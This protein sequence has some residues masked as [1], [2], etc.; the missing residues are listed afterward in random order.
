M[1]VVGL[2]GGIGSGK[3]TVAERFAAR[4]VPVVD[5]DAIARDLMAQD[6]AALA[7]VT[8]RFGP[9]ILRA[10]G[11]LDRAALRRIVFDDPAARA[12]LEGILH[13]LI[14][15]EA[16]R[17]LQ[18][19]SASYALLAVPLLVETGVCREYV[20]RVLTIEC[21]EPVRIERVMARSG[22]TRGEVAAIVAAQASDA[23]RRAVA[24]DVLDNAGAPATL[25]AAVA[26]LHARY[27]AL[28]QAGL[29]GFST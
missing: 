29:A 19:L 16:E 26:R 25:D 5:T 24:D 8:A 1:F 28:A 20:Q 18:A 22:L 15:R 17:R 27:L 12:V 14:R 23:E 3:S 7:A 21:P 2:T 9:A 6:A 4:G 13:P 11:T 10:D